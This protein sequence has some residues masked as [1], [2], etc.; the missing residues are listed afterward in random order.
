ME[1]EV[2]DKAQAYRDEVQRTE[3]L[4]SVM[5]F[6]GVAAFLLLI[7]F[8]VHECGEASRAEDQARPA[9]IAAC[10]TACGERG[11]H[12]VHRVSNQGNDSPAV[13]ECK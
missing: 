13:C 9:V 8:A 11:V 12:S 6:S 3:R 2:N 1:A 4:Q 10:K 5:V 7:A